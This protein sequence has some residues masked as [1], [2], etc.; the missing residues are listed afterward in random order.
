MAAVE[1]GHIILL[2][3][4]IDSSKQACE[5]LLSVNVLLLLDNLSRYGELSEVE[6]YNLM[7][8]CNKT[9]KAILT[10]SLRSLKALLSEYGI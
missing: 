10:K 2:S 7:L 3:H 8:D 4:L 1:Y 6:I 9:E 5:V